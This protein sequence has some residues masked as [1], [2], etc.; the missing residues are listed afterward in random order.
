MRL[1]KLTNDEDQTR[2]GMQWGENVTHRVR[3]A[4]A[5]LCTRE[6]IH[7]YEHPLLAAILSPVHVSFKHPQLW[8][9]KGV[10]V[11][12]DG[13]LKVGVKRL[14]TLHKIPLPEITN[15]QR[16]QLA[17]IIALKVA[18][19]SGFTTWAKSW[20]NGDDKSESAASATWYAASSRVKDLLDSEGGEKGRDYWA[21]EAAEYAAG[22]AVWLSRPPKWWSV[23]DIV[24]ATAR[25][26]VAAVRAAEAAKETLDL[27]AIMSDVLK[28]TASPFPTLKVGCKAYFD[29]FAGML[30]CKVLSLESRNGLI[31]VKFKLTIKNPFGGYS[32]REMF[33]GASVGKVIP[34]EAYIKPTKTRN[35]RILPYATELPK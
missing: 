8:E 6:V 30:P 22:A 4:G 1:Y 14:T 20:L 19:A 29:S 5:K 26:A 33:E 35:G 28:E 23:V 25:T 9:A 34:R 7:A 10:V 13:Q 11:A 31:K 2:G 24:E 12:R 15:E 27:V 3:C 16:V 18:R 17:I 32:P 21:A